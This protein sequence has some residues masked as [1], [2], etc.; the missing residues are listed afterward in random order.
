MGEMKILEKK[1]FLEDLIDYMIGIGK[2]I[3]KS[4]VMGYK[5]LDLHQLFS[6]VMVYGGFHEVVKKVGTWAKI[7][8]RLDNFDASVT[9]ASYR[10]KKNYERCLLDYEYKCFPENRTKYG[11]GIGLGMGLGGSASAT[12]ALLV[13]ALGSSMTMSPRMN[14]HKRDHSTSAANASEMI[15][16]SSSASNSNSPSSSFSPRSQDN[17]SN[18][19]NH[20]DIQSTSHESLDLMLHL[21]RDSNGQVVVPLDL[22]DCI[23]DSLGSIIPRSPYITAKHIWSVGFK[24]S[25]LLSANSENTNPNS[26]PNSNS[27]SNTNNGQEEKEKLKI[28]S[29]IIDAGGKPMFMITSSDEPNAP[30][31]A[32]SPSSAWRALVK[33]FKANEYNRGKMNMSTVLGSVSGSQ[34]F[35]TSS[36]IIKD[37]IRELPN[38]D[39]ALQLQS[40][41]NKQIREK[42]KKRKLSSSDEEDEEYFD[43]IADEQPRKQSKYQSMYQSSLTPSASQEDLT[44]VANELDDVEDLETAI[45][46]LCSLKY[47][48]VSVN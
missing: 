22:G 19:S 3:G 31:I 37:L 35:G 6:E 33:R 18:A 2:P 4:P 38:A 10:L 44:S 42:N 41:L 26:S 11:L 12:S 16:N 40:T 17:S 30:V 43:D 23:V 20:A 27:N 9:D 24:S 47:S 5:E 46:T 25:F 32:T 1:E 7:W 39:K 48:P 29:Q 28:V 34:L 36:P 45:A 13:T 14:G 15:S 8:K 21:E